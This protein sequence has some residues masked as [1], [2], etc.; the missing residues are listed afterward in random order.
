MRQTSFTYPTLRNRTL[1]RSPDNSE[2]FK[3]KLLEHQ[4]QMGGGPFFVVEELYHL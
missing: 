4:V 3:K 1:S 2:A